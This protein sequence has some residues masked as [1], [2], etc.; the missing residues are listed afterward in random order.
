MA[1]TI[2]GING[3]AGGSA[4]ANRSN[5]IANLDNQISKNL[6]LGGAKGILTQLRGDIANR[7]GYLRLDGGGQGGEVSFSSRWNLNPLRS[8]KGE[9]TGAA[10]KALFKQG[11]YDTT[12]LDAY[13]ATRGNRHL[14]LGNVRQI[15]DDAAQ[16]AAFRDAKT[17]NGAEIQAPETGIQL[18]AVKRDVFL[19]DGD[20][21]MDVEKSTTGAQAL[22]RTKEGLQLLFPGEE[23]PSV[24]ASGV[25]GTVY[26]V[27]VEGGPIVYKKIIQKQEITRRELTEGDLAAAQLQGAGNIA[28]PTDFFIQVNK[29]G[30]SDV[31]KVPAEGVREWCSKLLDMGADL[32]MV[33]ILMPKAPGETVE[34]KM[35]DGSFRNDLG[36]FKSLAKGLVDGL[37]QMHKKGLVFHDLK[38]ANALLDQA[39]GQVTLVDLGEVVQLN[40]ENPTTN[41]KA[42]SELMM[43]PQVKGARPHGTEVDYYSLAVTLLVALEPT[44]EQVPPSTVDVSAGDQLESHIAALKKTN[45]EKGEALESALAK[46]PFAKDL[47]SQC[48]AAASESRD[49]SRSG[50]N[51]V[52]Q[53]LR[54]DEV[55]EEDDQKWITED[56]LREKED[57]IFMKLTDDEIDLPGI[58]EGDSLLSP[59]ENA[60]IRREA[61]QDFAE[62]GWG[63]KKFQ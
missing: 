44:L 36:A 52:Q 22:E 23:E 34:K 46:N 45:P 53:L 60:R 48:F 29:E 19:P 30:A 2:T 12:H 54:P 51:E 27:R 39:S 50:R 7:S 17:A 42:G 33:G 9:V 62:N 15:I 63:R 18:C 26:S 1:T 56:K 20:G 43:A 4:E 55:L 31:V 21:D 14:E 3:R 37:E 59:A 35:K 24:L 28:A 41:K 16:A 11:G 58:G 57:E 38:P 25:Q 6:D 49:V 40:E 47:V 32:K 8:A 10:L 61:Q 13:L 5:R